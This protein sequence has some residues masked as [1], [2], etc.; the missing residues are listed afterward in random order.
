MIYL[1]LGIA[2]YLVGMASFVYWW[3]SE[4][5]LETN[6]LFTIFIAGLVG[7]FSFLIGWIIHGKHT[8]KVIFRKRTT[9]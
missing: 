8:N 2:W 1:L 5:D 4:Y 3:T 7:P 6:Q 9:K